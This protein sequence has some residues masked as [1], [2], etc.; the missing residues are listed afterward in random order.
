MTK[1]E[2][3]SINQFHR[4]NSKKAEL[5]SLERPMLTKKAIAHRSIIH[6]SRTIEMFYTYG[7][8]NNGAYL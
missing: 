7:S 5:K 1:L 6:V 8:R 2:K 4:Q 3:K